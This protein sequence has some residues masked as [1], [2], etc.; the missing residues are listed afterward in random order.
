MSQAGITSRSK[1]GFKHTRAS[2]AE[3][4]Q[5]FNQR[6]ARRPAAT[7]VADKERLTGEQIDGM[8]GKLA[9]M[10]PLIGVLVLTAGVV[11]VVLPGMLGTPLVVTGGMML[12]PHVPALEK[13]DR[14][15]QRRFP[16][17]RAES[18]RFAHRFMIDFENRYPS[19]KRR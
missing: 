3:T 19:N 10:P 11:G 13:A 15:I 5:P 1:S 14:W 16:A 9:K 4:G 18:L 2:V 7:K 6:S 12:A 17:I 8:N